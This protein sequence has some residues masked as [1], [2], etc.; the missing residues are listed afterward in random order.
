MFATL[1]LRAVSAAVMLVASTTISIAAD[2]RVALVI[3]NSDYRHTAKLDNPRNDAADLAAALKS[4]G[5]AVIHGTDLDKDGMDRHLQ[6]F[7]RALVGAEVGLFFYAG[8]GLQVGGQNYL[9]PVDAELSSVTALDFE[10]VRLDVI[11]RLMEREAKSNVVMLDACRDNPLSR[12]L[13]RAM[14]MRSASIGRGLAAA[15]SGVGTLISFSTQPG[16]VALDGA[17]RNSPYASALLKHIS[18]KGE[19]LSSVLI[20][21]RNDVMSATQ[22]RQ[23]PWEHTAL[24]SKLFFAGLSSVSHTVAPP[25]PPQGVVG[26]G[27]FDGV[28]EVSTTHNQFCPIKSNSFHIVIEGAVVRFGNFTGRI[29]ADGQYD[30]ITPGK[31]NPD[32]RVQHTGRLSGKTGSGSMQTINHKC[33]GTEVVRRVERVG[34]SPPASASTDSSFDGDWQITWTNNQHCAN[35]ARTL[36]LKIENGRVHQAYRDPGSVDAGG[37]FAFITESGRSPGRLFRNVGRLTG[38]AGTGKMEPISGQ[39]CAGTLVLRRLEPAAITKAP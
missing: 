29:A 9:V 7:A 11:Q 34:L 10:M 5:F 16:N 32:S 17:G 30:L 1:A 2:T 31:A 36:N 35:A 23:V 6:G 25:V 13:A 26:A 14:G 19:D 24:R 37:N 22:D 12:N 39:K 3:G 18:S 20:K 27:P 28:W 33:A 15:E 4:L 38:D 21:V 8:H